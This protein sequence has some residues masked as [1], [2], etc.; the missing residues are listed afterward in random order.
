[1]IH[2]RGQKL[3]SASPAETKN[4][5]Y[6][7]ESTG[8][9][10]YRCSRRLPSWLARRVVLLSAGILVAM[11]STGCYLY[12]KLPWTKPEVPPAPVDSFILRTEG[13]VPQKA[14]ETGTAEADLVGAQEF[15][16]RGDY[17]K[18]QTLFRL[19]AN[20]TKYQPP[21][22]Q[23]ARYY[24]AVSMRMQ[25]LL[26]DAADTFNRLLNDFPQTPYNEQC[27]LQ[28]YEI[29]NYWLDDTR[30]QL[31][32]MREQAEGKRWF[33]SNQ[34]VH[35]DHTKPL[36]DEEGR[37]VQTLERIRFH[38]IGPLGDKSLFLAG[39]VMFYNH[40]YKDADYYF[41]QIHERNR[42]SPLAEPAVELA[43]IC[44]HMSTGG[45]DYDGRPVAEARKL[46]QDAMSLYPELAKK[47]DFLLKQ[48]QDITYQ[49]AEKDFKM[50]EFYK[51][52]NHPGAACFYY[53]LVVRR[54]QGT[55]FARQ[56]E[57]QLAELKEKAEKEHLDEKPGLDAKQNKMIK[58]NQNP[59]W[60]PFSP[61]GSP[62][63]K[64]STGN[65]EIAPS[66]RTA[67]ATGGQP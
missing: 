23:E 37:A 7:R 64:P 8:E 43:I 2:P 28:M 47:K 50:A 18:A 15:F 31:R 40:N 57:K 32:E 11:P 30:Q 33:V 4:L 54:Y 20:N 58:G 13:L 29:A 38:N 67:A 49:Q 41:S 12:D 14:P 34:F 6:L 22:V 60:W 27:C 63:G 5:S 3:I 19:V 48:M 51:D 35:F 65:V 10:G 39:S 24:E 46:V 9:P 17:A 56:A 62:D 26:P 52:R 36:L 61:M 1:M 44:K 42:N 66:P 16:R 59:W 55:E 45:S 21:I 53:S 25:G